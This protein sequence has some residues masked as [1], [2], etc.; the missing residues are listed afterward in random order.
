MKLFSVIAASVLLFTS[1]T[2]ANPVFDTIGKASDL[3]G[4]SSPDFPVIRNGVKLK[5]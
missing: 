4:P 2:L 3:M 1:P 5:S